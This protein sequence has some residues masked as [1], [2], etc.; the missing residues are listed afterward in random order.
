MKFS[1]RKKGNPFK[2]KTETVVTGTKN[3]KPVATETWTKKPLGRWKVTS[4]T[5]N[6][7]PRPIA[8]K[9]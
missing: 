8:K 4:R 2:K 7:K 6:G 1:G 9:K 5:E 3:G